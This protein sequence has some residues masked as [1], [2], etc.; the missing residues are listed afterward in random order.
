[1]RLEVGERRVGEP[2]SAVSGPPS[3]PPGLGHPGVCLTLDQTPESSPPSC[4]LHT[5]TDGRLQADADGLHPQ[6]P[7]SQSPAVTDGLFIGHTW[8]AVGLLRAGLSLVP[9]RQRRVGVRCRG[10]VHCQAAGTKHSASSPL[11]GCGIG[12]SRLCTEGSVWA[13]AWG[14]D[15]PLSHACP[16]VAGRPQGLPVRPCCPWAS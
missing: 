12:W 5:H 14:R 16:E 10:G 2:P 1:M 3:P 15:P 9:S 6:A 7:R 11:Q 13:R 4:P 8:T